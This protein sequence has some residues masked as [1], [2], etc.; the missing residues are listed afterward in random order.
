MRRRQAARQLALGGGEPAALPGHT[1]RSHRRGCGGGGGGGRQRVSSRNSHRF[2]GS[3]GVVSATAGRSQ[4]AT[5]AFA[6]HMASAP[7]TS[8]SSVV[9]SGAACC[10]CC[11]WRRWGRLWAREASEPVSW[12]RAVTQLRCARPG[13]PAAREEEGAEGAPPPGW[14][15]PGGQGR[16]S[17]QPL[18]P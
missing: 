1:G 11:R 10:C 16:R 12:D 5:S 8:K 6:S 13:R 9:C 15:W 17:N 2:G 14:R 3:D 4:S 18:Q 7:V